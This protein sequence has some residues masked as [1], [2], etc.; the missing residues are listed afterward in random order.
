MVKDR[1]VSLEVVG[2]LVN[3][4]SLE[5]GNLRAYNK[6]LLAER[7]WWFSLSLFTFWYMIILWFLSF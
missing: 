6:V 3:N 1:L 4:E 5:L 2:K 7:L